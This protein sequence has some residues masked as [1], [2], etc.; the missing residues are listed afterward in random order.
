M[1]QI[2]VN[3][4]YHDS[5]SHNECHNALR[6]KRMTFKWNQ[7]YTTKEIHTLFRFFFSCRFRVSAIQNSLRLG[8]KPFPKTNIKTKRNWNP[9]RMR[10]KGVWVHESIWVTRVR[11]KRVAKGRLTCIRDSNYSKNLVTK[12]CHKYARELESE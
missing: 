9:L 8:Q 3:V 4:L 12:V 11:E 7:Y 6:D 1:D 2:A 10:G 5:Q